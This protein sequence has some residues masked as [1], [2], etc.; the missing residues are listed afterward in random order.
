[1]C[2]LCL[3]LT[4]YVYLSLTGLRQTESFFKV[5]GNCFCLWLQLRPAEMLENYWWL[6]G[7][8]G[9]QVDSLSLTHMAIG[10][11]MHTTEWM[12]LWHKLN[13]QMWNQYFDTC[14]RCAV[15]VDGLLPIKHTWLWHAHRH[16][17]LL[18]GTSKRRFCVDIS[19]QL[20]ACGSDQMLWKK[21][22]VPS[23]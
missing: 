4:I 15:A 5:W 20:K 12:A 19:L 23:L 1:M 10:E 21:R 14:V 16:N 6:L 13:L 18:T 3:L 11:H 9:A 8:S 22:Y 2:Q 7:G 17:F